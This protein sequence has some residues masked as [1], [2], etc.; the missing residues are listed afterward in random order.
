[1]YKAISQVEICGLF[2]LLQR[3]Q[4]SIRAHVRGLPHVLLCVVPETFSTFGT[5]FLVHKTL[6]ILKHMLGCVMLSDC[7][8][9]L[10]HCR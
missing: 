1:M 10:K 2:I 3:L 5:L 9:V 4:E 8:H 7:L 6:E